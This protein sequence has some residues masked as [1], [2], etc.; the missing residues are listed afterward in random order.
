MTDPDFLLVICLAVIVKDDDTKLYFAYM[1]R[2]FV[3][4]KVLDQMTLENKFVF[5]TLR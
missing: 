1:Y 5:L 4:L 3:L 2:C